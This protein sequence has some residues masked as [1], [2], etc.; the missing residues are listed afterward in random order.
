MPMINIT[1]V[2]SDKPKDNATVTMTL[3]YAR[4]SPF[5]V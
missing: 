1:T 5:S 4:L 3:K 2:V